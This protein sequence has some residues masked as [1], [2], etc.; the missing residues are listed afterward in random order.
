MIA[1]PIAVARDSGLFDR[2]VVSTDSEEI[3]EVA[4]SFG[5]ETPFVRPAELADDY[6]GTTAVIRH[7]V[8]ALKPAGYDFESV[9]CIYPTNPFLHVEYLKQGHELI[10]SGGAPS[11][12]TV[13]TFPYP[14][15][16]A[17]RINER[18]ELEVIWPEYG[19]TR[20]QD[21]PEAW[22]DAGQFYCARTDAFLEHGGFGMP[23]VRPVILPRHLVHDIDTE[24]DWTRAEMM[25]RAV[26][27]P[28]DGHVE[29]KETQ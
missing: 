21:L 7:A 2:I 10:T 24:E 12:Y 25:F 27:S 22:Q 4:Q 6:T 5:A 19:K 3:A 20:S 17:R 9:F 11:A 26:P 28:L 23:G 16:R 15:Y 18:G 8:E 29:Q 13:T 1:W 14:I